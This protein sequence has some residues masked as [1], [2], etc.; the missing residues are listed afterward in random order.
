MTCQRLFV[1]FVEETGSSIDFVTIGENR[2]GK[3]ERKFQFAL[4][5]SNQG[6]QWIFCDFWSRK[7]LKS[8]RY[9][10][11]VTYNILHCSESGEIITFGDTSRSIISWSLL[12]IVQ[13]SCK[14]DWLSPMCIQ[15]T[16]RMLNANSH[17]LILFS[18]YS[19]YCLWW[20]FCQAE[21]F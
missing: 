9:Y 8:S 6:P 13:Q 3:Q 10:Q 21:S 15:W 16:S 20:L 7:L 14:S 12:Q 18:H 1:G 19:E 11:S 4:C 5:D 2:A 17:F